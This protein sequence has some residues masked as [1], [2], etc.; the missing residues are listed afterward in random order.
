[1]AQSFFLL[2]RDENN[3]LAELSQKD[4]AQVRK[5]IVEL[6]LATDLGAHF[7]FLAQFKSSLSSGA[8]DSS[9]DKLAGPNAYANRLMI[10]KMALKCGD[11]G[12]STKTLPLHEKWTLRITEEFY[13][14]GDE[15]RR[16]KIQISPFMDRQKANLPQSQVGF[17]DFLVIP[18]SA[19]TRTQQNGDTTPHGR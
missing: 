6:V 14:Q 18:M 19:T 2:N 13:R 5:L 10:F 3:I 15:E 17:L 12:H 8:L 11:L 16:R 1:M 4:Y 9:N 7:D